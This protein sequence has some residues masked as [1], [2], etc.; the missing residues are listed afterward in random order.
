MG[1]EGEGGGGGDDHGKD[2][3]TRPLKASSF[4]K[5]G[6]IL[7]KGHP[8]KVVSMSTSKT[9]KHGHAKVKFTGID[10]FTSK[11]YQ[12]LQ[13]STHPMQEVVVTKAEYFVADLDSK[14]GQLSLLDSDNEAYDAISL[15][16]SDFTYT[17]P[18]ETAPISWQVYNAFTN[19]PEEIG[20]AVQQECRDRSR[21]PSS[22]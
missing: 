9:G 18:K 11:K 20:R 21:M 5:G 17:G 22:A 13:A 16:Q 6:F 1:D 3:F 7:L 4:R 8:C 2:G 14:S 10:I 12:E 19:L 15:N